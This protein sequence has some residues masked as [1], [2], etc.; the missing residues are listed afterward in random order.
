MNILLPILAAVLFIVIVALYVKGRDYAKTFDG[1]LRNLICKIREYPV[2][3]AHFK[4]LE[5]EFERL[6]KMKRKNREQIRVAW[7]EYA[8]KFIQFFNDE[9]I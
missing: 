4:H 5:R 9:T 7:V 6:N 2:D 8:R 1:E 3:L